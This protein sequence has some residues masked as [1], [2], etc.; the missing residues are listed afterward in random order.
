[1]TPPPTSRPGGGRSIEPRRPVATGSGGMRAR[2]GALVWLSMAVQSRAFLVSS[3]VGAGACRP[4]A[5]DGAARTSAASPLMAYDVKY[6]PNKWWDEDDIVPGFGG[7]W[8]GDPDAETHHVSSRQRARGNMFNVI[9]E[10]LG[11]S[12]VTRECNAKEARGLGTF[13][14]FGTES[15]EG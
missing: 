2:A 3:S 15:R 11:H 14:V 13:A 6:S 4:R 7:I 8:P 5:A 9:C 1:M 12:S 10:E